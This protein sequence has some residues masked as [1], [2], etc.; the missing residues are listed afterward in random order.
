ML[1][2]W[3][4]RHAN[5]WGAPDAELAAVVLTLNRALRCLATRDIMLK[6]ASRWVRA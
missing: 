3:A 1:V 6:V 4:T 2:C 5:F